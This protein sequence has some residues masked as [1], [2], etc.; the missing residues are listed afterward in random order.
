METPH[1]VL[2]VD[3]EEDVQ[4]L[5]KQRFRREIKK[6]LLE[7]HFAFSGEDALAYL[8]QE[9]RADIVL[10]LSDINMPGMSGLELLKRIKQQFPDIQVHM[11]TAYGDEENYRIAI[12]N[13]ADGY[14]TKPLDFATLKGEVFGL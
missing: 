2:I 11:I 9:G 12:D 8:S 13:G 3:D 4:W 6:G 10:V 1:E 14:L 5:F 7:L